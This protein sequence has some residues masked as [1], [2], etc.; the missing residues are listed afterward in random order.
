MK[1]KDLCKECEKETVYKDSLCV[2]CWK[3]TSIKNKLTELKKES[4]KIP[5]SDIFITIGNINLTEKDIFFHIVKSMQ[6]EL[7][8]EII[9]EMRNDGMLK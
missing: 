4:E 8:R 6:L 7:G 5:K 2:D 3:F 9:S 1:S